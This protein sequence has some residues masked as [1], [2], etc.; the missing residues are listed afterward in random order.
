MVV[1]ED[2]QDCPIEID[3]HTMKKVCFQCREEKLLV[4]FSINS[5][6]KC[7]FHSWCKVCVREMAKK[8]ARRYRRTNRSKGKVL[9]KMYGISI[10]DYNRM[11]VAQGGKCAICESESTGAK[12][13]MFFAVDHDH[14]T[15]KIRGLLC[16]YCNQGIGNLK[17]DSDLLRRAASY[18]ENASDGVCGMITNQGGM[19]RSHHDNYIDQHCRPPL[20]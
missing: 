13:K 1:F 8:Y 15:G 18:L 2:G 10:E 6:N 20:E 5:H 14:I 17:D 9:L 12:G 3:V 4:E 16:V 19:G 11:L 7:G